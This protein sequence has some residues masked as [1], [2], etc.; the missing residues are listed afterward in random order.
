MMCCCWWVAVPT[1]GGWPGWL[2]GPPGSM[3]GA[4]QQ[5][6]TAA[7]PMGGDTAS[8]TPPLG[9]AR[10]WVAG[11]GHGAS[12]CVRAVALCPQGGLGWPLPSDLRS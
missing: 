11:S 2:F 4:T 8:S 10:A 6:L 12:Q 9:L 1:E 7:S 3:G 5:A